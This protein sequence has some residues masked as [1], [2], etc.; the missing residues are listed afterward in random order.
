MKKTLFGLF[1]AL[2]ATMLMTSCKKDNAELIL[3]T[4]VN[5][6]ATYEQYTL[7]G[8]TEK[9]T[10]PE[11]QITITFNE[12]G[13]MTITAHDDMGNTETFADH[14]IV[15]GDNMIWDGETFVIKQLYKQKLILELSE[16]ETW[17][18]DGETFTE[19]YIIHLDFFRIG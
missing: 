11:G 9:D 8:E 10:Y 14:Y 2:T 15:N 12:N 13:T 3:G 4:W 1:L 5:T 19:Q 17:E 16:T 18:E 6:D 7:N